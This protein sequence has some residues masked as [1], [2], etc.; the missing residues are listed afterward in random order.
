MPGELE[1]F[2][3]R[4]AASGYEITADASG[5]FNCITW[6]L[7]MSGRNWDFN[8][9][10]GYWPLSVPR[11]DLITTVMQ[12]FIG[13]GFTSCESIE[14]EPGY[15]KIALYAFVGRFTHA[16]RQLED[17]RWTSKLGKREVITHPSP[18]TLSGGF[19]GFVHCIMRRPSA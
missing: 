13:E 9:P 4:L 16:A 12:L 10:D 7:G 17:G 19:F 2:F 1:D 18:A 11:N 5:E 14:P 3:P 8:D 6:V 15:E